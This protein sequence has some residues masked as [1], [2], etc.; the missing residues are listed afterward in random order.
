MND[1]EDLSRY[2]DDITTSM[3]AWFAG[4]RVVF[5]GKDLFSQLADQSW[6]R[7]LLYGITGKL[8]T[9]NQVRLFESIWVI[10]TS[11]PDPRIWNN[12]VAAMAGTAR[13]TSGLGIC[14]AIATSEAEIYGAKPII[15]V[16]DFLI[17]AKQEI[18]AGVDLEE[19]VAKSRD[20]QKII[21]GYGRPIVDVDERIQPLKRRASELGFDKGEHFQ[22]A[23]KVESILN[24]INPRIHMNA[25]AAF[26]GLSAD[27][28]LSSREHYYFMTLCFT[29]GMFPCMIDTFEK[30]AGTYLPL[31]CERINYE[32]AKPRNWDWFNPMC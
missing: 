7:V 12:G 17:K 10:S 18:D 8:F 31:R 2:E 28:G 32:G 11:Y 14:S 25:A 9:D 13:S 27:Q 5:R 26:A 4:K 21:P 30:P 20:K 15:S 3:G 19:I 24:K 29:A 23:F 16:I 6:M 1:C 22:L